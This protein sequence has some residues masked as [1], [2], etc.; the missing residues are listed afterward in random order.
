MF[1]RI[2]MGTV[3]IKRHDSGVLSRT[4]Q[5]KM[6][7]LLSGIWF[8]KA[9]YF[10]TADLTNSCDQNRG[11]ASVESGQVNTRVLP[12]EPRSLRRRSVPGPLAHRPRVPC[13]P[14]GP[15]MAAR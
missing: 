3:N 4:T 2:S 8:A 7:S 9:I 6:R 11:A 12:A 5:C 10:S 13:T 1:K 15:P 14:V